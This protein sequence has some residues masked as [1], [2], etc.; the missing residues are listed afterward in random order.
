MSWQRALAATILCL[1]T[2]AGA[3]DRLSVVAEL[4]RAP[5]NITVTP[6]HLIIMSLHQFYAPELRVVELLANGALSPFPNRHWAEGDATRHM[7]FDSVLG[8]QSDGRGIVWLLDNG[9][10]N[11]TTPKLVGWDSRTGSLY[12]VI[13]LPPPITADNSFVNDLAVDRTHE[14]VYIADPAGGDNAALIVV[15]LETGHAR[16]VL[17]GH[18][19]VVP[20]D[21]DLVIDG[22]PVRVKQPDGEI[23]RPRVGVNPI[24]LDK[25]D[26]W[27]YY[28]PMHGRSMYRIQTSDL[29][30]AAISDQ[31]LASR[32]ERFGEKPIS[33]GI[34]ID[35]AG[36]IYVSDLTRKAIGVIDNSGAYRVLVQDERLAWPDAFSFGPDGKLY[37]VANKLHKSA[38]L[39]AGEETAEPPFFVLKLEPLAPGRV[40]R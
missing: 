1:A 15:N 40:G 24:A 29:R 32:V 16:R 30:D 7:A 2:T 20:K 4:E 26:R 27:L 19:S 23:K 11:D 22:D 3:A 25:E 5:G 10:R 35:N 8:L 14:H 13:H 12:R 39:N 31:V 36:N 33:D 9:L 17:V 37:T 38:F 21:I 18:K 28:G 34:A 6:N